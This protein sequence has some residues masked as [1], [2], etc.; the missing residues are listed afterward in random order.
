MLISV[1]GLVVNLVGIFVFQHGGAHGHS[2]GG[3]GMYILSSITKD[4]IG[5]D[6]SCNW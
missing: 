3:G 2:H 4:L 1:L 6:Y 5:H